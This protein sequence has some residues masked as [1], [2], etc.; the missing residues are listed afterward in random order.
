MRTS[1]W[2]RR[3]GVGIAATVMAGVL[4]PS[5]ASAAVPPCKADWVCLYSDRNFAGNFA[6]LSRATLVNRESPIV[7][8]GGLAN[9]V[10]SLRNTTDLD[11][12]F[13]T[14]PVGGNV[15][16]AGRHENWN[17]LPFWAED[18]IEAIVKC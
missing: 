7:L 2:T 17:Q 13:T 9:R 18:D 4:A 15:F 10:S 14:E 6:T 11:L 12:C 3:V 1:I 16:R 8:G 5:P